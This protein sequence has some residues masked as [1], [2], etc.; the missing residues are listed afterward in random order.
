VR[1]VTSKRG[2]NRNLQERW[3]P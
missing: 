2:E 3:G 1:T